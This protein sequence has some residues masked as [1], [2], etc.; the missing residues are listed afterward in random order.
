MIW[1][2]ENLQDLVKWPWNINKLYQ[3][4]SYKSTIIKESGL[5]TGLVTLP[6][7]LC[8]TYKT[9]K[10]KKKS[11]QVRVRC[12]QTS[13][14]KTNHKCG[15]NC[16]VL[17]VKEKHKIMGIWSGMQVIC[18]YGAGC[19]EFSPIINP[20][21]LKKVHCITFWTVTSKTKTILLASSTQKINIIFATGNE[22]ID[23]NEDLTY[24]ILSAS[25][26]RVFRYFPTMDIIK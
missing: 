10:A 22:R 24:W 5:Q 1:L 15:L 2:K 21:C 13:G 19:G 23:L 11:M 12:R 26:W 25:S 20:K 6:K 18:V 9:V 17:C 4:I 8:C 7:N 16:V 14:E 3:N